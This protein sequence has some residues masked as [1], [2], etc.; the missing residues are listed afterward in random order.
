MAKVSNLTIK[1]QNGT[2][3]TYYASWDFTETTKT[4]TSSIKAGNLVSIKSGATYYNGVAIP[5]WVAS[6]KWYVSEVKGDRAVLGKNQSGTNNIN[7]PINV[8]NLVGG[9][10]SSTSTTTPVKNLDYYTVKWQYDPGEGIFFNGGTSNVTE[11]PV[12]YGAPE[13]TT[14]LKVTVTPVAKKRKVNGKDTPYWTGTAV[15]KTYIVANNPPEKPAIPTVVIDKYTLTASLENIP[16]ART[17]QIEFQVYNKF[18]MV[19]KGV[20]NVSRQRASFK[21]TVDAGGEYRVRCRA[22]NLQGDT[23]IYGEWTDYSTMATTIPS[24]PSGI[25]TIK[26]NSKTSVYLEWPKV[27]NAKT[28]DIEYATKKS[29]FNITN[30]TSVI[31]GIETAKYEVTGLESGMEYFFRVRA[32]NDNGNSSWSGVKSII[33]GKKPE[34]PTTWSLTTTCIV[35]EQLKLYW[36][37]NSEDGS[38]QTVAELE[39]YINGTKETKTIKNSTEEEEKD[40][41]SVYTINTTSYVEGTQIKWRVRTAGITK[42]YGD[43]SIQRT[44]DVYAPPTL[45][46]SITNAIGDQIYDVIESFPIRIKGVTGPDT[47]KPIGYSLSIISGNMYETVDQV[48]NTKIVNGGETIYSRYFDT[49]SDLDV[50]LSA[51]DVDLENNMVYMLS[52][53]ASMDSG[54]TVV[55]FIDFT[56]SWV[57]EYFEPDAGITIDKDALV[58][59][60]SP[61]CVNENSQYYEDVSLSVYRREFDG[62]FTELAKNIP[63][64]REIVITDPHP[65]LDYA[66][67]RIVAISNTTGSVTYYDPPGQPVGCTSVIIQWDEKK[68]TFFE[69]THESEMA[70]PPWTGSLLKLPYNIDIADSNKKDVSLVEYIGRSHPISYYGTQLGVLSKWSMDIPKD[71]KDT[72]YALRRLAIWPGDVYVR[73]PSGSGYWA[74]IEVSFSQKHRVLTIPVALDI[75]RVEGGARHEDGLDSFNDANLRVL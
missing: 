47:Q 40:K 72:L 62:T 56:V 9:T 31:N 8:K 29:Y 68:L 75:T 12:T 71:D 50:T 1:L 70:E 19:N 17:D 65:A 25:T 54:L 64:G 66:R 53:T 3:S 51:N 16:D 55:A 10:S 30:Q 59:Y 61:Y 5:D 26:A 7:S 13:N 58:A 73:E 74:N 34:S 69:T 22:I 15:S 44:I 43:W 2:D 4:T 6:Q 60:I 38:S 48:G 33:I 52:C 63:N 57:D 11:N 39:L 42:E 49:D 18:T 24:T 41:T 14:R 27:S 20:G 28:Y 32:V 21:C 23:K 46:L 45:Q 35:G 37:H 67:Y 36:V